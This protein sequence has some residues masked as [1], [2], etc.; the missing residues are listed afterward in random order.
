MSNIRLYI[1]VAKINLNNPIKIDDKSFHYLI[2]VMRQKIN[3]SIFIFNAIDG[4]FEAKITDISKKELYLLPIKKTADLSELPKVTLAFAP[5]KNVRIDFI[6]AKSCEAGVTNFQPIITKHTIVKTINHD[7]FLANIKE[8]CEQS[9]RVDLPKYNQPLTLNK[10]LQN[11]RNDQILLLCDESGRGEKFIK[12]LSN[13]SYKNKEIVVL[14]GP[15][16]GFSRE[17]FEL[18]YKIPNLH[19]VSLGPRI[20]RADTAIIA[21]L[22][23]VQEVLN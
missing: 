4:E 10:F 14:I 22:M 23:L 18:M 11:C 20:L 13:L 5:V 15:E 2:K 9:N 12:T 8:A 16:G 1:D 19:P 6:A 17:E 3:D 21:A 7:R